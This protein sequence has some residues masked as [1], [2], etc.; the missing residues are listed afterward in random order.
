MKHILLYSHS[1]EP[2]TEALLSMPHTKNRG[3][4]P[5]S[6][7]ELLHHAQIVDHF[8]HSSTSIGWTFPSGLR[9][10]NTEEYYMI[11]RVL[12]VPKSLFEDFA[13]E[14]RRYAENEF[15]AYLLFAL[16]AFPR[17]Y[18]RPGPFGLC[19]NQYSL[20]RQWSMVEAMELPL[21]VPNYYLGCMDFCPLDKNIVYTE[22]FCFYLWRPNDAL[23]AKTSFAFERPQGR[24]AIAAVFGETVKIFPCTAPQTALSKDDEARLVPY[25]QSLARCFGYPICEILFFLEDEHIFFGV[26]SHVPRASSRQKW[27][28]EEVSQFFTRIA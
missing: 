20:P 16:E 1:K 27:F 12:S 18:G 4:T 25:A 6:L 17:S 8:D 9:V 19:G 22:P 14:D 3:V 28:F 15:R 23:R 2:I 26:A 13:I 5:I 24:P 7:H 11:N 21:K 10:S